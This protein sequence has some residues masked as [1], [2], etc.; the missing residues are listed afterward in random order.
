MDVFDK[1]FAWRDLKIAKATG[2]Y[3][4]FKSISDSDATEVV[5]DGR[6]L[7]DPAAMRTLGFTYDAVGAPSSRGETPAGVSAKAS[8]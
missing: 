3:P 7:L 4:Y 1:A 5:I 6:R 8:R 2:F